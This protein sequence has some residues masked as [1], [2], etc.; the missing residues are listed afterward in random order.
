[1]NSRRMALENLAF[2]R[3]NRDKA[4]RWFLVLLTLS[5]LP[6]IGRFTAKPSNDVQHLSRVLAHRLNSKKRHNC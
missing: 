4:P 3:A 1:M 2:L 5:I 6:P